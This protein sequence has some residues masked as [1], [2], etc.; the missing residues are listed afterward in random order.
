VDRRE[1]TPLL[2]HLLDSQGW[3]R[4]LVFVGSQKAADHVAS[5]LK[6]SGSVDGR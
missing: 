5:K 3:A 4:C 1:R 2:R 6:N